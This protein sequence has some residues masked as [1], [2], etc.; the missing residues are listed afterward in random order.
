L[1]LDEGCKV[2][3]THLSTWLTTNPSQEERD[4]IGQIVLDFYMFQLHKLNKLH[5]DP[6][7]GNILITPE[8][9]L[10]VL[11]FGCVK[12]IPKDF[13]TNYCSLLQQ[14]ILQDRKAFNSLLEKLEVLLEGDSLEE[15]D[16]FSGLFHEVLTHIL[17][18]YHEKA[19]D[20]G[21]AA[22]F[23]KIAEMGES[24]SRETLKTKYNP[25][26]G[27]THFI[28]LNRANFGVYSLL[29]MLKANVDTSLTEFIA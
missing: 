4:R 22:Y 15:R 24:I 14:E 17:R 26:R 21:N 8:G 29:H 7:P 12:G 27:S 1:Q 2:E 16:Y 6:H 3:G 5:A 10:G 19:F 20:F 28:Y 9:K 11:D 23:K 25:N 13:Y 18:P